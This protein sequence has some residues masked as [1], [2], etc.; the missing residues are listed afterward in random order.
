M[1]EGAEGDSKNKKP[2]VMWGII[3][4][5]ITTTIVIIV[6]TFSITT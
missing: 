3:I 5:V 6:I 1:K 2:T 4:M